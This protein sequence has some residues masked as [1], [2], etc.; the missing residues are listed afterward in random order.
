MALKRVKF[1]NGGMSRVK[2]GPKGV[3]FVEEGA[4]TFLLDDAHAEWWGPSEGDGATCEIL[5]EDE[6]AP[7]SL[8]GL[9]PTV[10]KNVQGR[11]NA[12][13]E[14]RLARLG[15]DEAEP[16]PEMTVEEAVAA[17]EAQAEADGLE[18]LEAEEAEADGEEPD[19]APAKKAAKK[20]ASRKG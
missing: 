20:R 14:K 13:L 16:I 17:A 18:S 2:P 8:E 11:R 10:R 6:L 9:E 1:L 7:S 4:D 5:D 15:D 19:P 12:D 3:V